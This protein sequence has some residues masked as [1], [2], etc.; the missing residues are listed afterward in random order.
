MTAQSS[1]RNSNTIDAIVIYSVAGAMLVA[2][3]IIRGIHPPGTLTTSTGQRLV[4]LGVPLTTKLTLTPT[5]II[6]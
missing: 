3:I 4:K 1:Q 6:F 5:G 2:G